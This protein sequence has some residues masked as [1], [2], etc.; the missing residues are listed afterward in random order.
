MSDAIPQP[1]SIRIQASYPDQDSS[2]DDAPSAAVNATDKN[3]DFFAEPFETSVQATINAGN[4]KYIQEDEQ[5]SPAEK[6]TLLS[7]I[8]KCMDRMKA[9]HSAP[10]DQ[11]YALLNKLTNDI[12]DDLRPFMGLPPSTT[13]VRKKCINPKPDLVEG[14]IRSRFAYLN[15]RLLMFFAGWADSNRDWC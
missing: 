12:W 1:G 3:V 4:I 8:A 11:R 15:F 6:E 2:P 10:I 5:L 7:V 9:I 13:R 14:E